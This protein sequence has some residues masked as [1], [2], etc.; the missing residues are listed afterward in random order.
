MCRCQHI[1]RDG[2]RKE[3]KRMHIISGILAAIVIFAVLVAVHEG[4]HFFAAKAVGIRVNEFSI[5]MGPQI[6]KRR[7]NETEYSLRAFPIGGYV[8]LEGENEASEDEHAFQNQPGWAKVLVLAAGPAMNFLLA[9]VILGILIT[10]SG[11]SISSEVADVISGSPA[12]EAGL[13]QGDV[14]TAINGETVDTGREAYLALQDASE[15]GDTVSIRFVNTDGEEQTAKDI[16]FAEQD[17]SRI[18]GI[19]FKRLHNP[20]QGMWYGLK[21]SVLMEKQMLVVLGQMVIGQGSADDVVG[22]I[23]IVSMVDETARVGMVNLIYLLALLSLNLGL[24]N[25]LPFPA[26]DGGRLLFVLIRAVTGERISDE[27]EAGIHFAGLMILFALMILITLKDV[28]EF[29]IK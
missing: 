12:Y 9:V 11:T 6:F 28:N 4:G 23:G 3:N 29:L 15:S 19:H 18:V 22:P 21:N 10:W 14:I 17:G 2:Y 27:A 16:A 5:G 20:F 1:R 26:L 7:K 13:R 8:A 24:V 25:I